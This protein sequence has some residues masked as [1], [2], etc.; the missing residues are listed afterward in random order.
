MVGAPLDFGSLLFF[1]HEWLDHL[2][3]GIPENR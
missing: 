1:V 2:G 3:S